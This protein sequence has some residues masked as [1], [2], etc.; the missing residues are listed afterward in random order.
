M[1]AM[2]DILKIYFEIISLIMLMERPIDSKLDRNIGMTL[3]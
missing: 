1:A 2:A 3:R